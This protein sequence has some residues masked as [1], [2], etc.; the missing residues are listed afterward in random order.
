[1]FRENNSHPQFSI[2]ILES[3]NWMNPGI[4]AKLDMD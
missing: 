3:T 4:K 2:F 1:M